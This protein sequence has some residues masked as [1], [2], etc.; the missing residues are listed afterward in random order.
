M[1]KP[2]SQLAQRIE[3]AINFDKR[4]F[5][6]FVVAIFIIIR[7]LTNEIILEAIPGHEQLSQDGSLTFFHIFNA[8]H[9]IWTPFALLWKF[10]L[11]TFVL[12][13][14]SFALGY[15]IS[16]RQL[17]TFALV[18]ETI[19]IFPELIKLFVFLAP[20]DNVTFQEIKDFYP[21]SLQHLLD[22]SEIDRKYLYPLQTINL[23]EILYWVALT[24]GVH[25]Y[26][27]RSLK[28]S[29]MIVLVGYVLMLFLWLG[30]YILVYK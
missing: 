8:L 27:K 7:Y 29:G 13:T 3:E 12:W 2:K 11:T 1:V 26:S 25:T 16:F 10:T 22:T 6:V 24:L 19:F 18:A 20:S 28:E 5:F 4:I 17:W 30:F 21:F 14:G 23:F 15:K 9:Y